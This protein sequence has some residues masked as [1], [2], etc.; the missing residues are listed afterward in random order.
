M[1]IAQILGPTGQVDYE[2]VPL[3]APGSP[4]AQVTVR[5]WSPVKQRHEERY[6]GPMRF[7]HIRALGAVDW[8][9]RPLE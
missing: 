7:A 8:N 3:E 2:R 9:N 6:V 4:F 5:E 1:N